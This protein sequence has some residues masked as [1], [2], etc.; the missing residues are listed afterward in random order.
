L[1][2]RGKVRRWA[3]PAAA[4]ITGLAS[5][6]VASAATVTTVQS[7]WWNE[8]AVG[9]FAV[10]S[11]T[12]S[13]QLQVSNG[14]AGPLA[15]AGVRITPA[16]GTPTTDSLTLKL[17]IPAN[18]KV[19]TPS[20]AACITTSPW[21][22]GADQEAKAAPGYT[23]ERGYEALGSIAATSESWTVPLAWASSDGSVSLALVPTPGTTVPFSVS[24]DQPTGAA[25]AFTV[26]AAP[27]APTSPAAQTSL[28]TLAAPPANSVP[29]TPVVA[30]FD[31]GSGSS[32]SPV[33]ASGPSISPLP[34]EAAPA[35]PAAVPKGSPTPVAAPTSV[36]PGGGAITP[37]VPSRV[38]KLVAFILLLFVGVA[39]FGLAGQADRAP[40]L[41]G[42]LGDRMAVRRRSPAPAVA[43]AAS[44]GVAG[45][46][47][48][49]ASPP[50]PMGGGARIRGYRAARLARARGE[51]PAVGATSPGQAGAYATAGAVPLTGGAHGAG[52]VGWAPVR[53]IGRFARPRYGPPRRI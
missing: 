32:A 25:V 51:W 26:A 2:L 53:G 23:C 22:P 46:A 48:E 21:K 29:A 42:P 39:L 37:P 31:L 9:P 1:N 27:S 47:A 12:S 14:L 35:A 8:A 4:V 20:V 6:S 5:T 13:D 15:F 45:A 10:P 18:S 50:A 40:R 24:Y 3:I 16:T 19:G 33:V 17:S 11:V 28:P 38:P 30:P 36:A 7:G 43:G 41:L 34:A 44:A 49:P 52:P